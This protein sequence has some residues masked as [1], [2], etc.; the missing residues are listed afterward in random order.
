MVHC[1]RVIV[2]SDLFYIVGIGYDNG[3]LLWF[4]IKKT[5]FEQK[6]HL[7]KIINSSSTR[8][9]PQNA[10]VPENVGFCFFWNYM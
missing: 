5:S 3:K 1:A 9:A 10:G 6:R 7:C 2:I 8:S 4:F